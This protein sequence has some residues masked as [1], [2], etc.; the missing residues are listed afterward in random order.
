MG[1]RRAEALTCRAG[2]WHTGMNPGSGRE[3]ATQVFERP[4]A[5]GVTA[6]VAEEHALDALPWKSD[7]LVQGAEKSE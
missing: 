7:R 3:K 6:G 5:G 2:Q 1:E 4:E